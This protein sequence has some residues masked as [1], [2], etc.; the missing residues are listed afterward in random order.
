MNKHSQTEQLANHTRRW[1]DHLYEHVPLPCARTRTHTHTHTRHA[2]AGGLWMCTHFSRQLFVNCHCLTHPCTIQWSPFPL[3]ENSD[4]PAPPSKSAPLHSPSSWF[5]N[6]T[7]YFRP[8]K[9]FPAWIMVC[10]CSRTIREVFFL[11]SCSIP[12]L[13]EFLLPQ[14]TCNS[15]PPG[16]LP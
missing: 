14:P 11:F 1:K 6:P 9:L 4:H 13:L 3:I 8:E 12:R 7:F 16:S 15:P 5:P 2:K 10:S